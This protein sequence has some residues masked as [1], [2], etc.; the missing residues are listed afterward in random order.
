MKESLARSA[1]RAEA[2][3]RLTAMVFEKL[4]DGLVVL[5]SKLQVARVATSGS[6]G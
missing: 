6:R 3:R 4:P 2:E 1:E 5:D